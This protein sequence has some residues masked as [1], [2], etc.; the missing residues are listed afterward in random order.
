MTQRTIIYAAALV[1]LLAVIG[2]IAWPGLWLKSS[3]EAQQATGDC[4]G[5]QVVN[6]TNGTGDKQSPAFQTKGNSIRLTTS[7][8]AT[9]QDP[10]A[11]FVGVSVKAPDGTPVGSVD[12]SSGATDSSLIHTPAGTYFLDILAANANY[13]VKAEDCTQDTGQPLSP[14]SGGATTPTP[15]AKSS[16]PPAPPSPPPQPPPAPKSTPAAPAFNA[17]GP[18]NGPVPIMP[19]G[20]CPKEFP[21]M[22]HKACYAA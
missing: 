2:A 6:T 8:T 7:F 1:L 16:P 11:A 17:G 22:R 5:A 12:R 15:A 14:V 3:A 4:P 9:S 13:T 10:S 20:N 21:V 18:K 19:S